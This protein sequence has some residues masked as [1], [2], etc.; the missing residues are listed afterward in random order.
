MAMFGRQGVRA[1]VLLVAF[2]GCRS[3]PSAPP[4]VATP[5]RL[6]G[7]R[8][9]VGAAGAGA[10]GCDATGASCQSLADGA[11]VSTAVVKTAPGAWAT[12]TLDA[13]TSIE[14]GGDTLVRLG[15]PGEVVVEGGS[16]LLASA[17]QDDPKATSWRVRLAGQSG[18]VDAKL[19][20]AL[21]VRAR[22]A[23]RATLTVQKGKLTL[24]DERGG[25]AVILSGESVELAAG[26]PVMRTAAPAVVEQPRSPIPVAVGGPAP[27][28]RGL[29]RMTARVPGRTEVVSGV[30]LVSHHIDVAVR[31]GIARTQVE[32][33]FANDTAQTLE[34]RYVFALP[35]DAT[36]SRLALWVG[37][38]LVE[39][40]VV[41]KKRAAA[42]FKGIVDDTVRPR[43][44]ALLEWVAGG[45]FSLKVFPIPAKGSRKVRLA[46]DQ[47]LAAADGRVRYVHP[48]SPG[49][50]RATKID[51]FRLHVS[52]TDT[53]GSVVDVETPGWATTRAADGNAVELDF[54]ARDFVPDRDFVATY[55]RD[56]GSEPEL[57]TYVPSWGAPKGQGLGAP[58]IDKDGKGW[59]ALRLRAELPTD[60]SPPGRARRDV[61][62]VVDTSHGQAAE[63][64]RDTSELVVA[65]AE[66]LDAD[67]KLAV[68]ACDSA[69]TSWPESGLASAGGATRDAVAAFLAKQTPRG[70]SDL[71]GALLD[72][73]R[74][75]GATGGQIVYLGDGAASSG[76]LSTSRIAARVKP[77]LAR[78][79][80][81][82]RLYGAGASLDA[83]AL[84]GLAQALGA[85]FDPPAT[86][87]AVAARAAR[88]GRQL[89]SAVVVAPK[90]EL[91]VGFSD[92]HPAT[93][94]N[95]RL[96][97]D[98]VVVGKLDAWQPGV[99]RLTGELAGQSYAATKPIAFT[100]DSARQNPLVPRLWAAARIADLEARGEA[101]A[102]KEIVEVSK[103]HHVMSRLTSLLVLEND[104]MYS[105]FGIARTA[106]SSPLLAVGG[107]GASDGRLDLSKQL[108]ATDMATLG[109][110][111]ATGAVGALR[112]APTS[113]L[114]SA[115][116][117][118]AGVASG[119]AGSGPLRPGAVGA[120][121]GSIGS[122]SAGSGPSQVVSAPTGNVSVGPALVSGGTV[123]NA[124]RVVA[125]MRA[126]F[127]ACYNRGLATNPELAGM[128]RCSA[129]IG[130]NGEVQSAQCSPSG[131]LSGEVA[132][133]AARRI[134]SAS[135]APPEGRAATVV[136]PVTFTS[137]P[138]AA[139]PGPLVP[140]APPV[141][142][143]AHGSLPAAPQPTAVHRVG[144][145][146]WTTQGEDA[147]A[148][149]RAALA[150]EPTSRK[151][152]EELVRAL[153]A[154]GRFAEALGGA[155]RFV[156]VDPDLSLAHELLAYA[157][158]VNDDA[159]GALTAV[160]EQ[161]ESEPA[162]AKWHV[163]AARGFE[164]MGDEKRACAHWRSLRELEPRP[165]DGL[166]QSLRCRARLWDDR[167]DALAEGRAVDKPSQQLAALLPQIE[168]SH[169][170]AFDKLAG[171]Q[172]SF[173][174][175]VSCASG[176]PCPTIA[177]VA[178]NGVVF[179]P[180]TPTDARSS[181]EAVGFSS[182][183]SGEYRT[184]LVGGAADAR[185]EV[186][187]TALGVPRALSFTRGGTQTIAATTLWFPPAELW[188]VRV[189]F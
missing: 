16:L 117:S 160:D 13:R 129:N 65:L 147:L 110:L 156:E 97:E 115:A 93:L 189:W 108:E 44:P 179:S 103:R 109:A 81:D 67:E 54:A 155:K 42:I 58:P 57:A 141:G 61:A 151:R 26:R 100:E 80:V 66:G 11:V 173:E 138:G 120:G 89:R 60:A 104:A 28:V 79:K 185:G 161:A 19:G 90:V 24:H 124:A 180:F 178:P 71:A 123:S 157:M 6:V 29:G 18:E 174:V 31:D 64:L 142:P 46:Y 172:G 32:E 140:S 107:P 164:A 8:V 165:G 137:T 122:T 169:A 152:H 167:D 126:G 154:R 148:K 12:L 38:K 88:M 50:D 113:A 63:R 112:A 62:I 40:E 34:G 94:P 3:K 4:V 116:S 186:K 33:E 146:A 184:V 39:G 56:A 136:I 36:I 73:T 150:K 53:R 127:R 91:P 182:L 130:P 1:I 49:A 35:T 45:D 10:V 102:A 111:G 55:A 149:L 51:D 181:A 166:Y 176:Q 85:T 188:G 183:R 83:V 47:V 177:V 187:L 23:E 105:E 76:E 125:G 99:V 134:Q 118:G 128:L 168:A 84:G 175:S 14:L 72:A 9:P 52:A 114:D 86:G 87:D 41:E 159:R 162:N 106:S 92:A 25:A 145:E 15:T 143:V 69:C 78:K 96:G 43:D 158:V 139:S 74:R 59:F 95:L 7:V 131:S 30:R 98:V 132:S 135:F 2:A 22:S 170:P 153:L 82:L 5:V 144:D 20:V 70:S 119:N 75:L 163:R 27:P 37:D 171:A 133:C 48:I 17:G 68:L 121:L 101:A 77:A 21:A